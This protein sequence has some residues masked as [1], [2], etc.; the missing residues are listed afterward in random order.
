VGR[1]S[2]RSRSSAGRSGVAGTHYWHRSALA[3]LHLR[4]GNLDAYQKICR[5]LVAEIHTTSDD[6]CLADLVRLACLSPV[7]V[8]DYAP[9]RE[10]SNTLMAKRENEFFQRNQTSVLCRL[11]LWKEAVEALRAYRTKYQGG[12]GLAQP[13]LFQ[14][15]AFHHVGEIDA[16]RELLIEARV[17]AE[18][19]SP[20][21]K[22]PVD[23]FSFDAIYTEIEFAEASKLILGEPQEL[24][25]KHPDPDVEAPK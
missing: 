24:S 16:A 20:D 3:A 1:S 11:K 13:M 9:I 21:P 14:A 10:I 15:I 22:D 19:Q 23:W 17:Y 8:D 18:A 2:C 7:G 12:L 5:Q 6:D 25:L 4:Q